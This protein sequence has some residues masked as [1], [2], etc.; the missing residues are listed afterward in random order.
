MTRYN[1]SK[2]HHAQRTYSELCQRW[3]TSQSECARGE[4]LWQEQLDGKITDLEFQALYWLSKEP[5]VTIKIDFRYKRDGIIINEDSKGILTRE[6]RAKLAWL[7]KEKGVDV[8][9]SAPRRYKDPEMK[10]IQVIKKQSKQQELA[11]TD[12]Y[13]NSVIK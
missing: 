1:F 10:K 3:F 4:E 12:A 13:L 8:I 5:K 7:K 9:L 11:D 6:Y 2:L